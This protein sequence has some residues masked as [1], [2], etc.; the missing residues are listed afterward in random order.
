[1]WIVLAFSLPI[2]RFVSDSSY[3]QHMTAQWLSLWNCV[4]AFPA[5]S[6]S[7]PWLAT[8]VVVVLPATLLFLTGEHGIVTGD[9]KPVTVTAA[10]LLTEG[11]FDVGWYVNAVAAADPKCAA[12]GLPY[13]VQATKTGLHSSYPAGMMQFA[14]PVL[15]V[16][17][18]VGAELHDLQVHCRLE[19]WTAAWVGGACLGLFFL[20]ALHLVPPAESL[21]VTA[22][23][24]T[25]SVMFSTVGQALWQHGGVIFWALTALLVEFRC[26]RQRFATAALIQGLALG[27][28]MACRLGAALFVAPFVFWVLCR[29]PRRALVIAGS[30]VLAYAPWAWLYWSVYGNLTGPSVQQTARCYWS[31]DSLAPLA[32]VL[33]SPS[34]GLFVYQPWLLLAAGAWLFGSRRVESP[35]EEANVPAGWHWFCLAFITL[36]V[37][38]I[39][40]WNCWWG[41]GC[42]GSRLASEA[43]P[44][45]AL[46]CLKPLAA[47][48][49]APNGKRL[50]LAT[51]ALSFLLHVPG[52]YL[53]GEKWCW[54]LGPDSVAKLWSWSDPP[55]LYPLKHGRRTS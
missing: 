46:L 14:V 44:L 23:L 31:A 9:S 38:I 4:E 35:C 15:A 54:D 43:V 42:W 40:M 50:V 16:S 39:S 19:K 36:H 30:A 8:L 48:W 7:T 53:R 41:G 25:G 47:L 29:A 3:R 52:V 37:S 1:L 27:C 2:L 26:C 11:N 21:V 55:F 6:K 49:A 32:G 22:V 18:L 34:R 33:F 45:A 10:S 51:A 17:R 24:A 20:I 28:M 5:R 13:F 12:A